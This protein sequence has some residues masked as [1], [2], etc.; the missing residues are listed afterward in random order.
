[1]R[2]W[3]P[4]NRNVDEKLRTRPVSSPQVSAKLF[5]VVRSDTGE[6]KKNPGITIQVRLKNTAPA[7]LM[8]R[9]NTE[10]WLSATD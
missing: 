8:S 5:S 6:P 4:M 3:H 10:F 7:R 2:C 1:M 9:K